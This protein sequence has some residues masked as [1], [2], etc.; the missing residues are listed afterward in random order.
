MKTIQQ[1]SVNPRFVILSFSCLWQETS[2]TNIV[3]AL[4]DMKTQCP[5]DQAL[6]QKLLFLVAKTFQA[7]LIDM[8]HCSLRNNLCHI[9]VIMNSNTAPMISLMSLITVLT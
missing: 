5:I 1:H 2:N 8:K 6:S 9:I 7:I 4:K 3:K